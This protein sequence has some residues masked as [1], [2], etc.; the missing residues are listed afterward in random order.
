MS[1]VVNNKWD[2][3]L[4]NLII[5]SLFIDIIQVINT[6]MF[7]KQTKNFEYS[8]FK[9]PVQQDFNYVC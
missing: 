2:I 5:D 7:F 1:K 9:G 8:L 3:M 4:K 6:R